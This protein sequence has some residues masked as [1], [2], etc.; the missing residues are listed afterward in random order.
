[1]GRVSE[2]ASRS[3]RGIE[4]SLRMRKPK[5]FT[6]QFKREVVEE[7]LSR[8]SG[9]PELAG[10]YNLSSRLLYH[11]TGQKIRVHAFICVL[12]ILL[13][14]LLKRELSIQGLNL[15][16]LTIMHQLGR[17]KEI[18]LF[19]LK[20]MKVVKKISRR[21]GVQQGIYDILNL[22]RHAPKGN[23]QNSWYCWQW[24]LDFFY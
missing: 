5:T 24:S 14:D 21:S 19:Y 17:I 9:P 18:I 3:P 23:F 20:R 16:L 22:E 7:I 1:M 6:S 11:W 15:G 13:L 8:I 10:R 12:A 2:R 4:R